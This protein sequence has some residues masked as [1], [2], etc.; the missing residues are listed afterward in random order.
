MAAPALRALQVAR[1]ERR[2][3]LVGTERSAPLYGRWACEAVIPIQPGS[4]RE[5]LAVA[6]RL[7]GLGIE[8]ALI[9]SPSFR[10]ALI[11]WLAG[12]PRRIGWRTDGRALLLTEA[13][14]QPGRQVHLARSYIDL[15]A[16]LGAD[17]EAPGDPT[18]PIGADERDGA[19][20]RL[21]AMAIDPARSIALMPGATY[22]ETKRWPL[23]H[24]VSFARGARARGWSVLVL[25]GADERNAAA[26]LCAEVGQDG[27]QSLAGVLTL[28]GSLSVLSL[29]AGAV[30]NDS[31]GM[32][33][34]AAAGTVVIGIFG[35]TNPAWTGPLGSRSRAISLGLHCA[36]CYGRTCP[37]QI[38]CLRDLSPARIL[39]ELDAL[40]GTHAGASR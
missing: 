36:P 10:A 25:G 35:S 24:W 18:L 3:L 27:A 31:G 12:I 29:V 20:E 16:R 23:A 9:L 40:L 34:A 26:R 6:G 28:R 11:P 8:S 39:S 19:A 33:L 4:A 2:W 21:R 30:S 22:G 5:T 37:T 13:V 38:E 32:H 1:P 7:R 14:A 17:P 15:A